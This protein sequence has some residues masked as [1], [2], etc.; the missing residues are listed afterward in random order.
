[1]ASSI[2]LLLRLL[3]FGILASANLVEYQK[4]EGN[5]SFVQQCLQS[6]DVPFS[7]PSN[8]SWSLDSEAWNARVAP[9]P[10]VVVFPQNE[11]QVSSAIKCA[12]ASG[13]KVTTI[14]GNR[15]FQS[16]AF[17]R[18][19]G[20]LV[21]NLSNMKVLKYDDK[22]QTLTYGGP[23]TISEA[24]KFLWEKHSR[25]LMHGR[26]PDVGMTG[27]AFGGGFGTLSRLHGTV[28]DDIV[29]VR[30][31]LADGKI[32]DASATENSE[33][34]WAV[35]GAA[36]SF[37]V[38]LTVTIETFAKPSDTIVSYTI[39]FSEEVENITMEENVG[40][41]TGLQA[42]AQSAENVD[43]ISVR[44]D[45]KTNVSMKGFFYGSTSEFD[46]VTAGMLKHLPARMSLLEQQP[47]TDFLLSENC[48]YLL[49]CLARSLAQTSDL[50][51]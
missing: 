17:G 20:A 32:V 15:S 39:G 9:V 34:L 10:S 25:A 16:M 51:S 38:V 33:L 21:I 45:L 36:A 14:G 3:F 42:W 47:Y 27:V 40:A 18:T 8:S 11:D 28:L 4:R 12:G 37:G 49:L 26:C 43:T 5:D 35:R 46:T 22:A 31:A 44:M 24:A 13:V 6:A 2:P 48:E 50:F 7:L 19:D 29:S 1:M 23:V 30:V 41:L